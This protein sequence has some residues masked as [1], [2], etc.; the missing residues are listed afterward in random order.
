VGD[1]QTINGACC[2]GYDQFYH[3]KE[4]RTQ[5]MERRESEKTAPGKKGDNKNREAELDEEKKQ[6]LR[7]SVDVD[8]VL[9][10]PSPFAHSLSSPLSAP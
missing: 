9:N 7:T 2:S 1:P 4:L 3:T 5:V 6:T 8:E 10:A